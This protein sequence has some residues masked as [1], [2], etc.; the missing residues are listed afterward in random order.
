ME[1][2]YNNVQ[3][4]DH[5]FFTGTVAKAA[6][7]VQGAAGGA[8]DG[9]FSGLKVTA[10]IGAAIG[11]VWGLSAVGLL[12]F[13]APAAQAAANFVVP[14]IV[15]QIGKVL[16]WMGAG[17]LVGGVAGI[18]TGAGNGIWDGITGFFTGGAKAAEQVNQEKGA[19]QAMQAQVEAYK[20]QAAAEAMT[21]AANARAQQQPAPAAQPVA[22]CPITINANKYNLP[23]QGSPMN[24]AP[25]T[26]Q[27][28]TAQGQGLLSGPQQQQAMGA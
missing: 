21:F 20:A 23:E 3:P 27:C 25:A 13:A 15:S 14:E 9:F 24:P 6:G 4:I 10:M 17:T 5:N 7:S 11:L 12:T 22:T 1:N 2:D 28:R 16:L 26:I 18:F 8:W 19:A